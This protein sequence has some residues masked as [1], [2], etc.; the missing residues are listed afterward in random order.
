MSLLVCELFASIQG[1]S[2]Y[3]GYPCAFVRLAGCN[4]DCTWCDTPYAREGGTPMETADVVARVM[5]L[6]LPL[7]EITGGEPLLQGDTPGLASALLERGLTVLLETNG[8]RDITLV[9]PGVVTILDVKC[10]SSGQV[11]SHDP[12]NFTR[13]RP[14]DEVK[15]VI[16]DREDYEFA[17]AAVQR[18]DPAPRTAHFSPVHEALHP[19]SL[20]EWIIADRLSVRLNLQLHKYV[21]PPGMRAV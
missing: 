10:P 11:S 19:R 13:L 4:L 17:K 6:G 21:W 16:A 15:L 14:H 8:S 5:D 2:S 20:A 12:E 7:V 3:A 1:E 9:D 18:F